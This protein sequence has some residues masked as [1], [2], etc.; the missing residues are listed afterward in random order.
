MHKTINKDDL[1]L[2]RQG[3]LVQHVVI[4]A[5][6]NALK[7]EEF[8]LFMKDIDW[9]NREDFECYLVIEGR[10]FPLVEVCEHW[11]KQV[12]RMVAEKAV[13][14]ID[15]KLSDVETLLSNVGEGVLR[16]ASERLGLDFE[17]MRWR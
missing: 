11:E 1:M 14:L 7:H 3:T 12:D 9:D 6:S 8:E 15:N 4:E 5:L 17:D 2:K 13:E 10:E 16:E